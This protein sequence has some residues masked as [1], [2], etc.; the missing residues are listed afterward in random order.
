MP[1][2]LKLEMLSR[3]LKK[4]YGIELEKLRGPGLTLDGFF[5]RTTQSNTAVDAAPSAASSS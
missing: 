3:L 1:D 5:R 2:A 4:Q